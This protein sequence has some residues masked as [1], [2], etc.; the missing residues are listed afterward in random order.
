M[1]IV[2]SD[3][4][5]TQSGT[6]TINSKIVGS[7]SVAVPTGKFTALK[8]AQTINLD[9]VMT[10]KGGSR[11]MKTTVTT[12]TW[13]THDVGVVKSMSDKFTSMLTDFVKV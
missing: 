3:Q 10:M 11:P 5:I 2:A 1:S 6:V 9:M 4:T 12:T 13:Y 7:E 8:V